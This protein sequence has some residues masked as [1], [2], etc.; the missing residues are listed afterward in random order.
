M[1]D[2]SIIVKNQGT[3]FLAGPPLVKMA[4]G[5]EVSAEELGGVDVHSRESGVTD[6]YAN[7]DHHALELARRAVARTKSGQAVDY[8]RRGT[9]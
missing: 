1:A 7:N 6:H 4:T 2:E 3:I 5:E 9:G 8:G